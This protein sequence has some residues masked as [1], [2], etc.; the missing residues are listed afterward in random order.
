[1]DYYRYSGDLPVY[2]IHE[3]NTKGVKDLTE[4]NPNTVATAQLHTINDN[5]NNYSL[6]TVTNSQSTVSTYLQQQGC[7][8]WATP[9]YDACAEK[10]P[11]VT[12]YG[13]GLGSESGK[14]TRDFWSSGQTAYGIKPSN[15]PD[16]TP[17]RIWY[18]MSIWANVTNSYL[19]T[20]FINYKQIPASTAYAG[21]GLAAMFYPH[22]EQ[23][24]ECFV[25][26]GSASPKGLG[27]QET[28]NHADSATYFSSNME[29]GG[30]GYHSGTSI[31]GVSQAFSYNDGLWGYREGTT[32]DGNATPHINS[33]SFASF[34]FGNFKSTDTT[35]SIIYW[36][37]GNIYSTS[38]T[39]FRCL[40]WTM[41]N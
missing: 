20:A 39:G 33:S 27:T 30:A 15:F 18:A 3:G 37:R 24:I 40:V 28:F 1:M 32:L 17:N 10:L 16:C 34:G 29:I 41:F 14:Y 23:F 26:H 21:P 25:L 9:K 31:A 4:N 11:N 19:G 12:T 13:N 7:K 36:G 38:Q 8:V 2:H 35:A 6:S 22:R 5:L